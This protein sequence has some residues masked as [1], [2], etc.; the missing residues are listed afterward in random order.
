MSSFFIFNSLLHK[1]LRGVEMS[2]R[3][4]TCIRICEILIYKNDN[5]E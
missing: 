2:E 1:Q 4:E 3:I 5:D